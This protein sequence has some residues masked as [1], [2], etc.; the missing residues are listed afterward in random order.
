MWTMEIGSILPQLAQKV[1]KRLL[2]GTVL[3]LKTWEEK[4]NLT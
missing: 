2:Y 3:A 4:S 1:E